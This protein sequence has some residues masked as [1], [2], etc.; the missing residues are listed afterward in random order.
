VVARIDY[1][2]ERHARLQRLREGYVLD[3]RSEIP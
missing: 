3:V 1:D 2:G